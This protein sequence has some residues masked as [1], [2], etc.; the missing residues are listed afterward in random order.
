[1]NVKTEADKSQ[2]FTDDGMTT[3]DLDESCQVENKILKYQIL[4][5]IYD[6]R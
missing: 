3:A 6:F 2:C 1:M 5:E 4:I